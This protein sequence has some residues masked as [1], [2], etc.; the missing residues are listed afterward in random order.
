MRIFHSRSLQAG[1][2]K[3][4]GQKSNSGESNPGANSKQRHRHSA[5]VC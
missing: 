4:A 5:K 3:Q 2:S 1:P